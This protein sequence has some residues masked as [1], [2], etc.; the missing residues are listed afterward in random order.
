MKW[1]KRN[2]NAEVDMTEGSILSH[3][4]K[5]SIPLIAGNFFQLFYNTVDTWVVGNYVSNEAFS[6]VG[7]VSPIINTLIGI[8]LGL[9][10]GAGVVIAQYFGA[11]QRD[12]VSKAVHTSMLGTF[13]LGIIF[14][15]LGIVMTPAMLTLMKTPDIVRP[16]AT[17]YLTIYFGG[18]IALMLYNMGTA[19]LQ[20]VGNSRLP[21]V[22]LVVCAVLNVILDLVF[23][24]CFGLGVA[25]VA[26]ATVLSELVSAVLVICVLVK[27]KSSVQLRLHDLKISR[28]ILRKILRIGFPAA[29]QMCITSFSNVFVQSYINY[30][31]P[32]AMSGWTVYNKMDQLMFLPMKSIALA[33]STFMGQNLGN[34][35]V[36]RAKKG[37]T[38]ALT[39]AL[40]S[41][42]VLGAP[43]IIFAPQ[44]VR[45]FNDK[46]EVLTYGTLFL[47][48]E[49]PFYLVTCVNQVLSGSLRGAGDTR[50]PV[51]IMLGSFV[52]FRQIY[53]F[54][55][56]NFISNTVIPVALSYPVGWI[57]CSI[58]ISLYYKN[59]DLKKHSLTA[60]KS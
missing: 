37:V 36:E 6:A 49:T 13:F 23:V 25:G 27:E 52:L 39:T 31:G 54:V 21:F 50:N 34:G 60:A 38:C 40:I 46:P 48:W 17:T 5:F 59:A 56:T 10:N 32:D 44:M 26:Y 43:L 47:R 1:F 2:N 15:I 45:F 24:L 51:L 29:L 16:E 57:I 35:N 53:L 30:F 20:A 11:G 58:G 7:T 28:G 41:T 18:V 8:F 14:T 42:A 19:I 4:I 33:S 9:S 22:F 3:I 55:M 12:N